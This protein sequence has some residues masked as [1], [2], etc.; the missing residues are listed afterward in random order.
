MYSIIP[1]INNGAGNRAGMYICT[2]CVGIIQSPTQTVQLYA[3]SITVSECSIR[4]VG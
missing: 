2:I 4:E 3:G 1:N